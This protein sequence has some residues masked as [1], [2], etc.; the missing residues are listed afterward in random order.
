MK[1]KLLLA[2]ILATSFTAT[3]AI[4][5]RGGDGSHGCD[6]GHHSGFMGG[7]GFHKGAEMLEREFSSD[8]IRTLVE[9]RLIMKGNPN[10]KVGKV[11]SSKNGYQVTI[12][13]QENS[14]V[15]ELSLAKNGMP[16]DKYEHIKERMEK[17]KERMEEK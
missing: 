4:A 12:V 6:K 15:E 10:V 5:E 1:K 2:T 14:L 13:T 11:S 16:Q 17:R 3:F 7:K 9:A 8:Q